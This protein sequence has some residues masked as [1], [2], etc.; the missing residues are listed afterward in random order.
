MKRKD[1]T[2]YRFVGSNGTEYRVL[3]GYEMAEVLYEEYGK[4]EPSLFCCDAEILGD[5]LKGSYC[6]SY[7]VSKEEFFA[8]IEALSEEN[9]KNADTI[10][11]ALKEKYY[12]IPT[13]FLYL[14]GEVGLK[15]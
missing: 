6:A 3:S 1:L 4:N 11:A 2:G 15:R 10:A 12:K 14:V 9:K 8:E 7:T 13:V 5:K